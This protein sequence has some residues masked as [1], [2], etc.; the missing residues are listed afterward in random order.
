MSQ[1]GSRARLEGESRE[2]GAGWSALG[3]RRGKWWGRRRWLGHAGRRRRKRG[4]VDC[5]SREEESR[6]HLGACVRRVDGWDKIKSRSKRKFR[7]LVDQT[8]RRAE[9]RRKDSSSWR[10]FCLKELRS[11]TNNFNYDNKLGEGGF[12]SVY[13]GQLWDGSQ[14]TLT[15]VLLSSLPV[16]G[17]LDN[18]GAIRGALVIISMAGQP[19]TA[20]VDSSN[21]GKKNKLSCDNTI[22]ELQQCNWTASHSVALSPSVGLCSYSPF[23]I[24]S[25]SASFK[26]LEHLEE[27]NLVKD[28][29]TWLLLGCGALDVE[30]PQVSLHVVEFP[31]GSTRPGSA[32]WAM[33][34]LKQE[35]GPLDAGEGLAIDLEADTERANDST[36]QRVLLVQEVVGIVLD[37]CRRLQ[38][39]GPLEKI[40]V[41]RLKVWSNS[42][43]EKF[44]A[45][46][47]KL[48]AVRHKNLLSFRGYCTE[49]Q[50]HLIVYDYM[51]NLSLHSHLHGYHSDECFLDWGRR[52]SIVIGTSEGIIHLHQQTTPPI[53]HQDI[54][55]SNVLLDSDFQARVA[56]FGFVKL[57]PELVS[58]KR[59]I[60]KN[61]PITDWAL[62]LVREEK[63]EEIADPKLNGD[64]IQEELKS[65]VIIALICAEKNPERR[66]KMPEVTGL[67]K[68]VSKEK[69]SSLENE[70]CRLEPTVSYQ[71]TSTPIEV[72]ED[73]AQ[74]ETVL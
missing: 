36:D 26:D 70:V 54:K 24:T 59:P 63:Y 49:G 38:S 9:Q 73:V 29:S 69:L 11:A 18:L 72:S 51:P 25:G 19:T 10:I 6:Q 65:V 31:L 7:G 12:G 20:V 42:E 64:Y 37:G 61:L 32:L 41:K 40:A 34:L 4:V 1:G 30:V 3:Q 68:G 23:A 46:V 28:G 16:T 52:M 2:I 71:G 48:G 35:D 14:D 50:E 56:D 66:P 45:E 8:R 55:A 53:I 15:R 62:P 17:V 33:V 39:V 27:E 60:H 47:E 13:W 44:A 21:L 67:L 58:G 57:I 5:G 74:R 43:Q 22:L